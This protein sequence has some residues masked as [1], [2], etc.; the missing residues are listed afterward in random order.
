M[1]KV[2][3]Y[4]IIIFY[5]LIFIELYNALISGIDIFTS[6]IPLSPHTNKNLG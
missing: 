1:E 3:Q 4:K 2:L 5:S 6:L